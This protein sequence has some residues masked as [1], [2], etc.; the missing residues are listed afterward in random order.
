MHKNRE[1][2]ALI[3]LNYI[4]DTTSLLLQI[5]IKKNDTLRVRRKKETKSKC[6][7]L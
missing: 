4:K 1:T 5:C 2:Y 3:Y 6:A 7:D